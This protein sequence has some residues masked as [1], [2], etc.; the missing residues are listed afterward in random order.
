MTLLW[1]DN[2]TKSFLQPIDWLD[3]CSHHCII[4]NP[5]KFVFGDDTVE[6]AGFE[7]THNNVQP[8]KKYLYAIRDFPS[9]A[10]ITDVRSWFGLINQLSYAFPATECTLP[11][12]HNLGQNC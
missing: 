2:L 1:A 12:C 6:S 7:I 11:F 3:I 8:C 5:E 4:L 10:N 9:P